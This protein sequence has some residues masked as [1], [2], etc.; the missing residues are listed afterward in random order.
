MASEW[1]NDNVDVEEKVQ[2]YI[3]ND[4]DWTE[5]VRDELRQNITLSVTVD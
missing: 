1:F 4:V 3:D 2:H 5:I